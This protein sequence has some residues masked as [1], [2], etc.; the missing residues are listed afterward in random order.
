MA[1]DTLA[2]ALAAAKR[3]ILEHKNLKLGLRFTRNRM[4]A[5]GF[6]GIF[7]FGGIGAATSR[8]MRSIGMRVH[9]INRHG[10]TSGW[11]QCLVD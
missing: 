5:G 6:C 8:L 11:T 4:L 9:A 1:E 2:I 10:R 7:G 3:L